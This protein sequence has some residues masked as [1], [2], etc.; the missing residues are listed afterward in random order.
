MRKW[1]NA[2]APEDLENRIPAVFILPGSIVRAAALVL[3]ASLLTGCP[4]AIRKSRARGRAESYFKAGQ[5]DRA[6]IEYL[7]LLRLDP[8]DMTALE[9]S[10]TM[11]LED[12]AP[13]RAIPFL[14]RVRQMAPDKLDAR[15]KLASAMIGLG[16]T[17]EARKE[18]LDILEKNPGNADALV[19]L[20]DAGQTSDDLAI[21][22]QQLEKVSNR[23]A[24]DI[25]FAAARVAMH[26]NNL[27]EATRQIEQGLAADPKST[28]LHLAMGYLLLARQE[29]AR[30]GD[31]F[32]AAAEAS[33]LRSPDRLKYIEFQLTHGAVDDGKA[34]LHRMTEQ[35]PDYLPAW[36][37]LTRISLAEQKYNEGLALLENVFSRDQDNPDG[38]LLQSEALLKKGNTAQAVAVLDKLNTTYP[39][40]PIIKYRLAQAYAA[41]K[42][43]PQARTALKQAITA[44][45]NYLEA[46]VALA[47][48]NLASG[49]AQDVVSPMEELVRKQPKLS[50][51]RRL[52]ASAYLGLGRVDDAAAL[53][54][55]QI[56]EDPKSAESYFFLGTILRLQKKNAEARQAFEKAA[57]LAPDNLNPLDQL[58]DIDLADKQ[59]EAA[60]QRVRQELAQKPD[61]AYAH[62]IEGKVW[63][64]QHDY[65]RAESAFRKATELDPNMA[66]A[67]NALVTVY[68]AANKLPQAIAELESMLQKSP[69]NPSLLTMAAVAYD[70]LENYEKARDTYEKLLSL[71]PDSALT[72]NNLA[73]LYGNRLNQL[74]RAV[75]LARKARTLEATNAA[76]ADTLGWILYKRAEYQEALPLLQEAAGK[77]PQ[78]PEIWFHLGLTY[79]MMGQNNSARSALEKAVGAATD[80]PDKGE[81]QRRLS[82]LDRPDGAGDQSSLEQ[83]LAL[84]KQQPDDPILL[85]KLGAAYDKAGQP[86]KAAE[87]YEKALKSNPNLAA[88]AA[89]LAQLYAGPLRNPE[90]A[91][92]WAKKAREL[93]P[94]DTQIVGLLGG[95]AFQAG[96]FSWSYS[97]LQESARLQRD[98]P[99]TLFD[100][101][102]AAYALGKV[103]EARKTMQQALDAAP[104]G[105]RAEEEKQ[106]VS[107]TAR[108]QVS[109]E[110]V[111]AESEIGKAL[112]AQPDY[113]PALMAEAAIKLQRHDSDGAT[114][115]Y[116]RVLEKFPDFAPAQKRLAAIYAEKPENAAKA[117][118]LAVKARKTLPD[119]P[120]LANTLGEIAYAR[121]EFAYA[122]RLFQ[123]SAARQSL[124]AKD[125]YYLGMAQLQTKDE[126]S[127]RATLTRAVAAGLP[128]SLAQAAKQKL[129]TPAPSP[130]R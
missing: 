95:I 54:R 110:T 121:N 44:S 33:P 108:D 129:A 28:R 7:N 60:L 119:D 103:A 123:E 88:A 42:N 115:I 17:K 112:Q 51:A 4:A 14:L 94:N 23:D 53:F 22:E 91:L 2:V 74:D 124:T 46:I 86:A 61:S 111:N 102:W 106:F 77:T 72:L 10:G 100:L 26:K 83:T 120:E 117:Y 58:V 11:W 92:D 122:I 56:K 70:K 75:E 80:F 32:K 113:V 40:N 105:P 85:S 48:L 43:I 16:A 50:E 29:T 68:V 71:N 128:E 20:A 79:Y 93:A 31:E 21:T 114:A 24:P 66:A 65:G 126:A 81:A 27:E 52:L 73:Y 130:T 97:L 47:Q 89:K 87:A 13:L 104:A 19:L 39:D 35:T 9:R 109:S 63:M 116:A 118:D 38:R 41:A 36:I 3:V 37:T 15:I 1:P 101:A 12:G 62:C 30:A 49:N 57:Q 96:N 64:A 6:K 98:N 59:F 18:V 67:Y 69:N 107:L 78:D 55:E 25:R 8:K 125:L 99:Q 84:L 34:A 127:G 90:K 82:Q 76:I 5:Y 45:P